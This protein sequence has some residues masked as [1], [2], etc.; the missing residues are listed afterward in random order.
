M[1]SSD[2]LLISRSR[3]LRSVRAFKAP[4]PTSDFPGLMGTD[5][6]GLVETEEPLLKM[7]GRRAGI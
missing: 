3:I 6:G 2:E 4:S 1:A 5:M 7:R